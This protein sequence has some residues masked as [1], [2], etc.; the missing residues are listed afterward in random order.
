MAG[1]KTF[2][3]V[4]GKA[5]Q[6]KNVYAGV[7]GKARKVKKIYAGVSG[8]ARLVYS[9]DWWTPSGVAQSNCLAAYRFKGASSLTAANTDLSGHGYNLSASSSQWTSADGLVGTTSIAL[10][11]ALHTAISNLHTGVNFTALSVV[12][13]WK[14]GTN[15]VMITSGKNNQGDSFSL[16]ISLTDGYSGKV[17]L[18]ATNNSAMAI[19]TSSYTVVNTYHT[20]GFSANSSG[21]T[22][23]VDGNS[24]AASSS[25]ASTSYAGVGVNNGVCPVTQSLA[26][27]SC[28]LNAQQQKDVHTSM[29][30]F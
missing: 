1:P 20:F 18:F 12:I 7:S 16:Q 24:V 17:K 6:V 8:K 30:S 19:S 21:Y 9:A 28:T 27:F 14:V 11:S 10:P 15:A 2:V 4:S 22:L 23:Y 5:K 26:I 25:T 13:R 29:I 3:G